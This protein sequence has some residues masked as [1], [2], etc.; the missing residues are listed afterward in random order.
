MIIHNVTQGSMEWLALRAKHFT[1]SEAPA[2]MGASKYQTRAQL[3]HQ[4]HTGL[5][6]EV[7]EAQQRLFDRGHESEASA[8]VILE[9]ITGEE[10]FPIVATDGRYLASVDGANM[11]CDTLFE[12]KLLNQDLV[13][14]VEN[15]ELEPH[16]Y[17]QLEHQLLVTGAERVIFVCS[18]GTADNFHSFN[19]V[20]RPERRE[21]L[22]AG[23]DQFEKDLATFQPEAP[24]AEVVGTAPEMLPALRIEVQGMVTASNLDQFKT[25][26]LAVIGAINTTL[27]DDQDFADAEKTVKWCA[28]VEGRLDA[29]KEHA[30]GQT[31]SID[32]M[33]RTIDAIREEARNKRL[34]LEKQ[35]KARKQQI[36][37]EIVSSA[38][39][40]FQTYLRE[41]EAGFSSKVF[42][43]AVAIDVAGAIK[44]KKT[45]ASLRDAASTELARAKVEARLAADQISANLTTLREKAEGFEFLFADA[46]Q[47]VLKANDDLAAVIG[48]R[49]AEHQQAEEKR[50]E[51]ERERIRQ[52]ELRKLEAEQQQAQQPAPVEQDKPEPQAQLPLAEATQVHYATIVLRGARLNVGLGMRAFGGE[53]IFASAGDYSKVIED[54]DA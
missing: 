32:E 7:S 4:K 10:F 2:M 18:D 14:Q 9:D 16:Y 50:L 12:H 31:A 17:W 54:S 24:Q 30:L 29:A 49:I 3:L 47:L 38:N 5:T 41:L 11:L 36:R 20:S 44:G 43:S 23:W 6:E 39:R 51:Q 22:I 35:V 28:D 25:H 26:A 33:F 19:Y 27:E 53:V 15:E 37:D 13:E 45:I 8:R 48:N 46:Q 42:M 1:A 40:D 52:E 21:Q 34:Q